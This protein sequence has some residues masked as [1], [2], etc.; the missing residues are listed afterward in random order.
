[1]VWQGRVGNHSPYADL[2]DFCEH[3]IIC[4]QLGNPPP[5]AAHPRT[6]LVSRIGLA[7]LLGLSCVSARALFQPSRL[8]GMIAREHPE[9]TGVHRPLASAI[10]EDATGYVGNEVCAGCHTAIYQRPVMSG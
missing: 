9:R 3:L 8:P 7:A 5:V 1:V 10:P 6:A 4:R 2:L